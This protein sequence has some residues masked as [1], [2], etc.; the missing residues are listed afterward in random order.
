M[1]LKK[2]NI[3]ITSAHEG[4][5]ATVSRHEVLQQVAHHHI[6][7]HGA[8]AKNGTPVMAL[9]PNV[10]F[11]EECN[12]YIE[13]PTPFIVEEDVPLR[14]YSVTDIKTMRGE[15]AK[16]AQDI[17]AADQTSNSCITFQTVLMKV[18]QDCCDMLDEDNIHTQDDVVLPGIFSC[19]SRTLELCPSR[20]GMECIAVPEIGIRQYIHRSELQISIKSIQ[21]HKHGVDG[22]KL[23][24]C[25]RLTSESYSRSSRLYARLIA[26]AQVAAIQATVSNREQS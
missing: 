21:L 23:E 17:I 20:H 22:N 5:L 8:V 14:W 2:E 6:H 15:R 25:L 9:R 3:G 7:H 10:R 18:F 12:E 11:A 16:L 24:E 4:D 13:S 26:H 19:L 1:V